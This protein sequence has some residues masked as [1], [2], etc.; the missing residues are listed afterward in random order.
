MSGM[1]KRAEVKHGRP[2][3]Y[4][5]PVKVWL[6]FV[7]D[8]PFRWNDESA[9]Y[10]T[11]DETKYVVCSDACRADGPHPNGRFLD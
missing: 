11:I 1:R 3:R 9:A 8:R 7:C 6:C 4:D 5:G 10:G 2:L